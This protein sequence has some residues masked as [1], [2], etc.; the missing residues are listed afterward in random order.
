MIYN[1]CYTYSG[2]L[3]FFSGRGGLAKGRGL[4][5]GGGAEQGGRGTT[6]GT[7]QES[8]RL[9]TIVLII[10]VVTMGTSVLV[11]MGTS[12]VHISIHSYNLH[13][14][15][16]S[17]ATA[18]ELNYIWFVIC[19]WHK[20]NIPSDNE[21][22][23]R[24]KIF[25][26]CGGRKKSFFM[27]T[28]PQV[29]CNIHY[30]VV[31]NYQHTAQI[32]APRNHGNHALT[33]LSFTVNRVREI[34]GAWSKNS[35]ARTCITCVHV[36]CTIGAHCPLPTD[37]LLVEHCIFSSIPEGKYLQKLLS[38]IKIERTYLTF[39]FTV[40]KIRQLVKVF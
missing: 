30:S 18:I 4:E 6:S 40:F 32:V 38:A 2:I 17:S 35:S 7:G 9:G 1:T 22:L 10:S 34:L 24:R 15:I 3:L 21:I 11:T 39:S 12:A 36:H 37:N 20:E 13:T 5:G 23:M 31:E 16:Q 19:P 14:L 8:D 29:K 26:D 27:T 28:I 33:S 25:E